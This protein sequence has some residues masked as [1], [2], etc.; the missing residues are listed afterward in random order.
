MRQAQRSARSLSAWLLFASLWLAALPAG[1]LPAGGPEA[2]VNIISVGNAYRDPAFRDEALDSLLSD[3]KER[4][5]TRISLRVTWN[6]MERE[7]G[8]L[9]PTILANLKRMFESAQTHGFSAMLDFHTLF[10]KDSYACPTWVADH[11]QDD[12]SPGLRSVAMIARSQAVRERYLAMIEGVLAELGECEAIDV[13]SVMNEPFSLEFRDP[14][15]W[16]EDVDQITT[17]IEDAARIVRAK[18]PGRRVAARFSG[19]VN[20]WSH[21]AGRRFDA[22]RLLQTLDIIGQ[23]VYLNPNDDDASK[24]ANLVKNAA[25]S[26]SWGILAEAAAK[27][28]AAGRALWITE[29]GAPWRGVRQGDQGSLELQTAY[30]EGYCRRFW[31]DSIQP[32]TVMA[33]V[34]S[35]NP[36]SRDINGLYDGVTGTFRPAFDVYTRYINLPTATA[37]ERMDRAGEQPPLPQ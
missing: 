3:L 17:V 34:L 29:F 27:C 8:T 6:S 7:E 31:G 33:W 9:N 1:A 12:G 21:F 32:E 28:R 2:G 30:F 11:P 19:T 5:V 25:P 23:N 24:G 22:D 26:L 20:P 36:K 16:S 37:G 10:M 18:A 35:P 14:A 13:V 15:R 4:G